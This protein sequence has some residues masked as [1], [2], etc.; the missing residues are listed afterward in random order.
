ME[1]NINLETADSLDIWLLGMRALP[2]DFNSIEAVDN[3][4][5]QL[6]ESL[7]RLIERSE[8]QMERNSIGRDRNSLIKRKEAFRNM[9]NPFYQRV[10]EDSEDNIK[11]SGKV[12]M[13]IPRCL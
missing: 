5:N 7:D 1:I 2:M 3:F 12:V 6:I 4:Y 8:S 10:Q 11:R 13:L 9:L